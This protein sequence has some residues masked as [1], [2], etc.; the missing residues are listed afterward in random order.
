MIITEKKL[1]KLIT[2]ALIKELEMAEEEE[3]Y[4]TDDGEVICDNDPRHHSYIGDDAAAVKTSGK[5]TGIVQKVIRLAVKISGINKKK[6]EAK[7]G[8]KLTSKESSELQSFMSKLKDVNK[9]IS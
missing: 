9:A 1:R 3:C 4:E 5:N 2:R 6:L 7:M 8:R